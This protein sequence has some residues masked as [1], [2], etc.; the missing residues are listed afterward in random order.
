MVYLKDKRTSFLKKAAKLI[1]GKVIDIVKEL[2]PPLKLLNILADEFKER[3]L[4]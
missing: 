1:V 4:V 3:I 2:I